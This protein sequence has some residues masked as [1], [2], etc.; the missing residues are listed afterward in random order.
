[1]TPLD[2]ILFIILKWSTLNNEIIQILPNDDNISPIAE[3][4]DDQL[5]TLKYDSNKT[6]TS[7]R[8]FNFDPGFR[9]R[10]CRARDLLVSQFTINTGGFE[11]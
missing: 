5:L 4:R 8:Y 9:L 7:M 1:M 6:S 2:P 10:W 11:L 3:H